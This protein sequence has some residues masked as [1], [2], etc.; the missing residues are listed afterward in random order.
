M[1]IASGEIEKEFSVHTTTVRYAVKS[2]V[3]MVSIKYYSSVSVDIYSDGSL[4]SHI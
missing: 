2:K 4:L 3:T 1:S